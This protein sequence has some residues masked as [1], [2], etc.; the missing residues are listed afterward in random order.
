MYLY[1]LEFV[2]FTFSHF[3]CAAYAPVIRNSAFPPNQYVP[4]KMIVHLFETPL[5]L[6][7]PLIILTAYN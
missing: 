2:H 1:I 6:T 4:L 5:E 3:L 7:L